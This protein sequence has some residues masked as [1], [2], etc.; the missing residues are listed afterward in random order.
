VCSGDACFK[1]T[2]TDVSA[3][4][5]NCPNCTAC[6]G[7]YGDCNCNCPAAFAYQFYCGSC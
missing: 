2:F 5:C 7:A 1:Y 4:S 6:Y 3:N